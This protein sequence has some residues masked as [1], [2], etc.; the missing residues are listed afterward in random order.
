MENISGE[1]NPSENEG[2]TTMG[3]TKKSIKPENQ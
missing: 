2:H 1:P 3:T